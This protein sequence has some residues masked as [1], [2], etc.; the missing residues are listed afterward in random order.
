MDKTRIKNLIKMD[1]DIILN[2]KPFV[3]LSI[4]FI[5]IGFFIPLLAA[6]FIP[7]A[8]FICSLDDTKHQ[9]FGISYCKLFCSPVKKSEIVISKFLLQLI[10][11][12]AISPCYIWF[13]TISLKLT[14]YVFFVTTSFSLISISLLTFLTF[15][16]TCKIY[17]FAVIG[18]NLLNFIDNS[19]MLN[20]D[21]NIPSNP[22]HFLL[23]LLI[24]SFITISLSIFLSI[25]KLE[26]KQLV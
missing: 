19:F 1:L 14:A 21:S 16:F 7:S 8:G 20:I 10:L 25:K 11:L 23:T 22:E 4:F 2:Q 9:Q 3:F 17:Y 13:A 15:L 24:A 26:R 18:I 6:L 12:L 5:I